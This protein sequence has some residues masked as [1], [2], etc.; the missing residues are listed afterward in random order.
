MNKKGENTLRC[1]ISLLSSKFTE[2]LKQTLVQK[3]KQKFDTAIIYSAKAQRKRERN[4]TID[5]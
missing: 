5:F 3:F 4:S 1:K 2:H